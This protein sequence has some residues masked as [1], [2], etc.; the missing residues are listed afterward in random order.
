MSVHR[1]ECLGGSH[2]LP[3]PICTSPSTRTSSAVRPGPLRVPVGACPQQHDVPHGSGQGKGCQ[4]PGAAPRWHGAMPVPWLR[5]LSRRRQAAASQ[6]V[7]AGGGLRMSRR[8]LRLALKDARSV[9]GVT[10][11]CN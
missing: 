9:A 2:L 5:V 8:R 10:S 3:S 1:A 6:R 7:L 4:L 11:R